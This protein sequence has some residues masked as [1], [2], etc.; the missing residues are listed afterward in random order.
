MTKTKETVQSVDRAVDLLYCFSLNKPELTVNDFVNKTGL[1]RTTVFRL[2]TSLKEK[3]LIVKNEEEGVYRLSLAFV[4]FGQIVAENLDI[5]KESLPELKKLSSL[6]NE[7]VSLNVLQ[8]N[9]RVCVEK[10]D[11]SEDIRQFVKLG[12]PYPLVRGASGKV[13]LAHCEENV[14][15]EVIQEWKEMNGDEFD[16]A[17][18]LKELQ[19][20]RNAGYCLSKNDRVLGAYSIS[21]PIFNMQKELIG[22]LSISG[23]AMRLTEEKEEMFISNAINGAKEISK[24]MGYIS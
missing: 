5:R 24:K 20:I 10:V 11:G 16:S 13:L 2:L 15:E 19:D 6:T 1:N 18:F 14:I 4:G 3:G 8:S 17:S 23:L 12:Y 21:T 9:R 7:T 22:G